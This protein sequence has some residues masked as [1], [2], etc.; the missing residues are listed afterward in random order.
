MKVRRIR[1]NGMKDAKGKMK[2]KEYYE[3]MSNDEKERLE[4]LVAYMAD[5]PIGTRL[6]K[7]LYNLE[8]KE[9][10]I[11]AF[12]PQDHRF[13]NFMVE[14]RKIIVVNAYRK[15]SQQ[16][17]RQDK[18]LLKTVIVDRQDYLRRVKEGTYYVR[19]S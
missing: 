8:D 17:S 18:N 6:P 5:S 9:N 15:H 12:K 4:Q 13:F 14:G 3:S 16:M 19:H 2:A 11:Y 10:G 7:T 1:S